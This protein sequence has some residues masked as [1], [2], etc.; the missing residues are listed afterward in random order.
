VGDKERL[1][2]KYEK[3][4]WSDAKI[5]RA[6]NDQKSKRFR[7]PGLRSDVIDLVTELTQA[8]GE[9]RLS[10][11]WYSGSIDTEKFVL[12]DAG[13]VTL[14]NFRQDTTT[15]RDETTIAIKGEP[16]RRANRRQPAR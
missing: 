10:L 9:V 16:T 2:K 12:N 14:E 11:H 7:S 15:L 3:K 8:F 1:T 5:Q 6:L 4:G 13:R